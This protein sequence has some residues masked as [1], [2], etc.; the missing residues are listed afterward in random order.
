MWLYKTIIG[1][2]KQLN[3]LIPI[4]F[5]ELVHGSGCIADAGDLLAAQGVK[6]PLVVTD[7]M[8]VSLG[9]VE[10]LTCSLEKHQIEY[11]L[12]DEVTPDPS[13]ATV[14]AGVKVYQRHNCDAIVALGGGSPIDCAKVI[15]AKVVK[16]ANVK[17][18]SGKLKVRKRLPPFMAI[19]TTAGTGSEA[20]IAAVITDPEA[21]S[22]FAVIDP[23][24]VP[25]VALLDP[26]LMVGLPKPVTA[27]TGMDALTHAIEAYLGSFSNEL[28]DRYAKEA[29]TTIFD[30]L[31]KAYTD[32][33]DLQAREAMAMASYQAGCAFT[34]A[35]VGYVHAI[36]HQ[37]GGLYHIPHGLAN[38]VL[39]PYVLRFS[40]PACRQRFEDMAA[41]IGLAHGEQFIEAVAQ[42]NQQLNIPDM[43]EQLKADDIP[44]I[45]RRALKEAHGTYPVP[46]YMTQSQCEALLRQLLS[47]ET[48]SLAGNNMTS[49]TTKVATP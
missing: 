31:P 4:P 45:A 33:S 36:A 8:L 39:L 28:T 1:V 25:Q 3:K 38:A 10:K 22:K 23:V 43:F 40:F 16:K 34:R 49:R 11:T 47:S 32:G 26:E 30:Q 15:G 27:A 6:K 48:G 41:L 13:I 21:R 44:E 29:I 12:F 46:R 42:L 18:L 14:N 5:P 9:I 35:F 20:T 2:N 37:L 7:K 17:A 19:P 24:L